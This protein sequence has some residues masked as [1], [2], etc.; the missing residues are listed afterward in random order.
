MG[1][2]GGVRKKAHITGEDEEEDECACKDG[3]SSCILPYSPGERPSH[4]T[5][6]LCCLVSARNCGIHSPAKG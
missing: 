6:F 5:L 1:G 4:S 3:V 2:E